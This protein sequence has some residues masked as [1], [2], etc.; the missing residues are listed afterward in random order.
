MKKNSIE[1]LIGLLALV[2][3]SAC[4]QSPG[5]LARYTQPGVD[6]QN[7]A[8]SLTLSDSTNLIRG[9]TTIR[10]TRADD[11][12]TVWFDL[13]GGK[14]DTLQTG[15]TVR[16][17]TLADGKPAPFNQRNDKV[18]INLPA[19][20]NQATE[21]TIRYDGTPKQGLIISRNK[22][23]DRTFFGDNWPNNARNYL[24]VVDHPSDKATCSFAVNAP[25]TYRVIANGK[26]MGE[27]SL[28][29]ARKLTRWQENTPIPTKVMVIGA[30]RF[31]VDEVGSINGVPVQSWLYPN[32]SQKGFVDYRP[33]KEILQYFIDRIG[34]YSYEKLANVESTTIFGGMEN[35]S[36]IFYN[37]KIIVGHKDSDVEA[38]LAHE[39]A[40]Q[41]FGNSATESDWSQLWLSEGFATY[42]SA[43][44]LEHAYGKDTLNAVLNQ[45]KGQI[46][47]F[48]ALKP[49]GTIVDSTA[50][51]LMDLLN[52]NSY[53]KGGWVLHMLRH[54]LGDDVFW[55]GIR[56]Y[57]T[58]YRNRNAQ[59]SD[60]QAIMEK[61]SGKKLGQFFQQW[62]YQPGFPEIV[63]SSRYDATKKSLVIDVRQAQRTGHLFTIPLTFSLRDNRGRELSRSSKL[64][65][66][67]QTQTYT[68][69]AATKPATVVIDPDNT[70]L[71]RSTQMGN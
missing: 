26:F 61:E 64:T 54:E 24:P 16:S 57:Y 36:C 47:R 66:S 39:I 8:F 69:P 48:S 14:S 29:N 9:E 10:F 32:D 63:W 55:K 65:L 40:H 53:Q 23:G 62:L 67:E 58:A 7:Y 4:S 38:L 60:L 56:A 46:F 13:I 41:W 70:V 5:Y 35:A 22:F 12:Q 25:A 49:K 21:L 71:M 59:S 1:F 20:P 31:V 2:A 51:N 6:V 42:F 37:E 17:V 50:S 68:I 33:A 15:M 45:N 28:P 30:A 44:Y 19:Q 3:T 11:R 34:P 18:F 27:S 43:L 52:P